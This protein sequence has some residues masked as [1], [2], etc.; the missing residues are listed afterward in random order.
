M[1]AALEEVA[2]KKGLNAQSNSIVVMKQGNW[3]YS[4]N[5]RDNLFGVAWWDLEIA[6]FLSNCH[7]PDQSVVK[8]QRVGHPKLATDYKEH[9]GAV[10]NVDRVC[11]LLTTRQCSKKWY[12]TLWWFILD[13]C[14]NNTFT[15][16][17]IHNPDL[18][19]TLSCA[20]IC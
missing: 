14:L 1:A 20:G 15:L 10:D 19:G 11:K 12:H 16:F 18:I 2:W 6:T 8:C 7:K 4:I 13:I 9:I 3:V 5:Q 17:R